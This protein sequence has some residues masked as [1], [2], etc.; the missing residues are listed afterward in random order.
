MQFASL[1]GNNGKPPV[2]QNS[3]PK[4]LSRYVTTETQGRNAGCLLGMDS[5]KC[6][7][8][9]GDLMT[10]TVKLT[11]SWINEMLGHPEDK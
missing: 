10:I 6:L 8:M 11:T 7:H 2:M 4:S 3:A 9:P 1:K 5:G